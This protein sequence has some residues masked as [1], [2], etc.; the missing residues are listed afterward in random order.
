MI[1]TLGMIEL[2][3]TI[4]GS[5]KTY[6]EKRSGFYKSLYN[7]QY[8]DSIQAYTPDKPYYLSTPE[9][10]FPRF[11]NQWGF[12]DHDFYRDTTKI[13]I[14]TY[15]DSYTEG[16][17]APF[18]SSYP[19]ILR[20]LLGN[21]YQV[22]NYGICGNDPGFYVTQFRKIGTRYKPNVIVLSYSI[23]DFVHDLLT[24]GGLERFTSNGWKEPK[25]PWWEFL[26]AINYTVRY[27]FHAAGI[28]YW[29]GFYTE[30]EK[31]RRLEELKPKWNEIFAE[32]DRLAQ[33]NGCRVLLVKRPEQ[34]EIVDNRYAYNMV[35]FDTF[36]AKH[37]Q[38]YHVDLLPFY[39]DSAGIKT[40][41]DAKPYFW[42]KDGHHNANGYFLLAR[43]VYAAILK[44][45]EQEN[46]DNGQ[47]Q[48]SAGQSPSGS[49]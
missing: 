30:K 4:T 21:D 3:L 33:A 23:F 39:R 34:N 9:Y 24:R 2:I 48:V 16:D 7:H 1:G 8:Y 6:I 41:Q 17:G 40:P 15:G 47:R 25:G 36:V 18:D 10:N 31:E 22:Q 49:P 46:I 27:A 45:Y 37:T 20:S 29:N 19:A 11:S 35:F 13:L 28:T 43:A 12:S 32:L 44:M 14:Q 38:F 5:T 42:Q 26:Y